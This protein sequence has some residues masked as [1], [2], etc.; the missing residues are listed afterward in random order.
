MS[1]KAQLFKLNN[2]LVGLRFQLSACGYLTC[3]GWRVSPYKWE[4]VD[5]KNGILKK[6]FQLEE[7]IS[8]LEVNQVL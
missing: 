2:E 4:I 3:N 7:K 8:Q 6:I 1:I 5:G